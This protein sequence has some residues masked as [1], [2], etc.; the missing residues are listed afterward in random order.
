MVPKGPVQSTESSVPVLRV[1]GDLA[2]QKGE[3]EAHLCPRNSGSVS[4]VLEQLPE[5]NRVK[6]T[7][8][9]LDICPLLAT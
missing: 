6:K 1:S 3:M 8:R 9:A 4:A 5:K 7:K 2:R